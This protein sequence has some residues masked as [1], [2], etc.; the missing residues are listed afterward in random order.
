MKIEKHRTEAARKKKIN[1]KKRLSSAISVFL[2]FPAS[3]P[4]RDHIQK[5]FPSLHSLVSLID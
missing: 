4:Q 3:S 1:E 5:E 2:S